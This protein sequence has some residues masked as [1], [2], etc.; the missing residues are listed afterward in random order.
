MILCVTAFV[1]VACTD[2]TEYDNIDPRPVGDLLY[3]TNGSTVELFK[4]SAAKTNF[5]WKASQGTQMYSVVFYASD[6]TTQI[7]EYLADNNG[8]NN[9][10]QMSHIELS[11][12]AERAGIAAGKSG[13][14]YWNVVNSAGMKDA[15][16][17]TPSKLTV[18]RY[19]AA[20]EKPYRL[21]ITGEG[22]EG[23]ADFT[24]A[25][26]LKNDG[27]TFQIYTKIDGEVSFVNRNEDGNKM[28]IGFNEEGEFTYGD[29][30]TGTMPTGVY[31]ITVDFLNSVVK[32]EEVTSVK[33]MRA[34]NNLLV[35]LDY[36]GLGRWK[37]Q[38]QVEIKWADGDDRYRFVAE[39]AGNK[40]VWG[41]SRTDRDA[42][43]PNSILGS[44]AYYNLIIDAGSG[45][46][47]DSYNRCFKLWGSRMNGDPA[48]V[49][50]HMENDRKWH[51]FQ[52]D[53][54]L[55]EV[56]TVQSLTAPAESEKLMLAP[57]A[58]SVTQFSWVKPADVPQL[59]LTKYSVVFAKDAAMQDVVGRVSAD[60][61]TSVDIK[62]TDLDNIADLAGIASATSGEIYWAVETSVETYTAMST[63]S[64]NVIIRRFVALPTVAYITGAGSE[65][66]AEY[67]RMRV[68]TDAGKDQGKLEIYA[69]MVNG[70][71]YDLTTDT[72]PTSDAYAEYTIKT[73][74]TGGAIE[75]SSDAD[76]T[77]TLAS[78]VYR[79]VVDFNVD[80]IGIQKVENM[81]FSSFVVRPGS[82]VT[83][84][85]LG[86]GTWGKDNFVPIFRGGWDD[87]RF[88]FYGNYDGVKTKLGSNERSQGEIDNE[89]QPG[90]PKYFIYFTGEMSDWDFYLHCIKSYR[91][92][93]AKKADL[94]LYMNG[95]EGVTDHAYTYIN[96][97]DK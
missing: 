61:N 13:D 28:T 88:G 33:M 69:R 59:K 34:N 86:N 24:Q 68:I 9:S 58:G 20:L 78:G 49:Y 89:P 81:V 64:R 17:N 47:G 55:E 73:L 57:T 26:P 10:F 15:V 54:S 1:G 37:S 3:P 84:D 39:I 5:E 67:G 18:V 51:E 22:S 52:L 43:E 8:E 29:D 44:D 21:F 82:D 46:V 75:Q 27:D 38:S 95:S 83:L 30:A 42:S 65:F 72:D 96:Y 56:P 97:L 92:N 79:V 4:Y 16:S 90:D 77:F 2:S 63:A 50:V 12:M 7:G 62:H 32:F 76:N 31:R 53:Y 45:T 48:T 70:A 23:G 36:A 35:D 85:Y 80:T 71:K 87:D 94:R 14:I 6:K 19:K 25:L 40:E 60:Y 93:T 41:S 74:A 11:I 91:A 66:G